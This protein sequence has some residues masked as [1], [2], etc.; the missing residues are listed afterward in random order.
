[1]QNTL[2]LMKRRSDSDD[3]GSFVEYAGETIYKAFKKLVE[4]FTKIIKRI[5]KEFWDNA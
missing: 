3:K 2:N 4:L 1:M 5:I